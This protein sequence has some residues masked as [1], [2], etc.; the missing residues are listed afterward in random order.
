MCDLHDDIADGDAFLHNDPYLGNT[1]AA[2]HT[3]LVPVFV[4]GEH[5]FTAAAK[6]HQADIGN[7]A[8]TTY[9]PYARDV[10][11]EGALIFPAVRV[12]RDRRD[13]ADIIR[14]CRRRIR[15]PD[16]WYGDYLAMI[17]SARIGERRLKELCDRYGVDTIKTFI[18]EWF[19]YSERKMEAAIAEFDERTV[20]GTGC[21]DPLDPVLPDGIPVKVTISVKPKDGRIELDLRDNID[22]VEAGLNES[23]TCS[24]NN[25][26]T[27]L[28]NGLDPDIPRNSGS[29]RRISVLLRDGSVVGIPKFPYSTSVA[30][31]NVGERLV[32]TTQKTFADNWDGQGHAEGACSIGPGFAVISGVDNRRGQAADFINQIFIGSQGG[33]ANTD[34]DGWLTYGNSVT[35]G[36]MFR[37]SIEVDE[38]KYPI[39]IEELRVRTDSEGAG[40]RRGAPGTVV[41]YGP[42]DAEMSAFYV[43]DG[44]VN[45]PRG[46]RGGGDAAPSVPYVISVDGTE[47]AAPPIGNVT[48]RP[49]ELLGQRLSGGGGYGDPFEREPELVRADVLARFVSFERARE[50]YGVA[51]EKEVLTDELTIDRAATA[52]LRGK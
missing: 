37:D 26:M 10:Y 6:A 50:V 3:I 1:H 20:T 12:Q 9:M 52:A 46:A 41:T 22:C 32:M 49:G 25:V 47:R 18:E 19:D 31:T 29:F 14:M 11:Q 5:L 28:L 21:H 2:D 15:V 34:V 45:P 36:L 24:I 27:G 44:M 4:D 7:S 30:T 43:T 33:P 38:Q 48:L 51:F 35:N 17:G 23:E 42:K 39:R 16:Q 13:V 40:R 8:A